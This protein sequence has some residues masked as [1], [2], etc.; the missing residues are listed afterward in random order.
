[1]TLYTNFFYLFEQLLFVY[2][3]DRSMNIESGYKIARKLKNYPKR[4]TLTTKAQSL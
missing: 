4:L 3:V 1:M 2:R